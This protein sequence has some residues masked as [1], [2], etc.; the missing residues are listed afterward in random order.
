MKALQNHPLILGNILK[1]KLQTME[2][3]DVDRFLT[4]VIKSRLEEEY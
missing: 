3:I 4:S 2:R 1:R